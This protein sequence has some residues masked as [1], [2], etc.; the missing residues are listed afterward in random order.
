MC[1]HDILDALR[2][3]RKRF[4]ERAVERYGDLIKQALRDLS[5]NPERPGLEWRQYKSRGFAPIIWP[6]AV[7]EPGP[8]SEKS[9][10]RDTTSFIGERDRACQQYSASFMIRATWNAILNEQRPGWWAGALAG[11]SRIF[12]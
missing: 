5:H 10:R 4:G 7:G 11:C 6:S 2:W 9:R 1:S 12:G 3:S 8:H